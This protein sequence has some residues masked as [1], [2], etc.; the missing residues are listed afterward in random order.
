ME[1]GFRKPSFLD[2]ISLQ[3]VNQVRV[4]PATD[5]IKT[6]STYP[7]TSYLDYK[8]HQSVIPATGYIKTSSIYRI[9]SI[10]SY[11]DYKHHQS[12]IPATGN[13]K[14]VINLSD[15]FY[16][17]LSGLQTPSI[18]HTCNRLYKNVINLFP[19][20]WI[21]NAIHQSYLQQIPFR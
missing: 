1:L 8:H 3:H 6:P 15:L 17:L 19:L 13:K 9:Y 2:N 10:P 21:T 4:I 20:I 7:L 16:S 14:N 11:L 18:S 5:L 12:V